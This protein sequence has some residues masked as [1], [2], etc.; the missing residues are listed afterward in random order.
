[1]NGWKLKTWKINP[2]KLQNWKRL[3]PTFPKEKATDCTVNVLSYLG[4]FDYLIPDEEVKFKSYILN[5]KGRSTTLEE[6]IGTIYDKIHLFTQE[7]QNVKCVMDSV[8]YNPNGKYIR[9]NCEYMSGF[10]NNVDDIMKN[11][12]YT[13]FNYNRYDGSGH[14][15]VLGKINGN[16]Y[17]IDPQ[18]ETINK[19]QEKMDINNNNNCIHVRSISSLFKDYLTRENVRAVYFIL[20]KDPIGKRTSTPPIT[21][22][23]PKS[24]ERPLKK[25]RYSG[26][27]KKKT[28]KKHKKKSGKKKLKHTRKYKKKKD[29]KK[30]S[31]KQKK[32]IK[33]HKKK[34]YLY[35]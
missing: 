11:G 26:G 23:K 4:V 24:P 12:E 5:I 28:I 13:I 34:I 22:R 30:K 15:V 31:G 25:R 3:D 10:L 20:V 18:Q 16:L 32:T 27:K 8:V 17:I 14:S 2:S 21:V 29:N 33:K 1:M 35:L 6:I 9:E 7:K 19:E